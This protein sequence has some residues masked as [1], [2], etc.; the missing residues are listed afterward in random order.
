MGRLESVQQMPAQVVWFD[1]DTIFTTAI[2][3]RDLSGTS[4]RQRSPSRRRR[5]RF[6]H[7]S[8]SLFGLVSTNSRKK[9]ASFSLTR[10][11]IN[12]PF[13]EPDFDGD[14]VH[15]FT[16]I[17]EDTSSAKR[18]HPRYH[19]FNFKVAA[20]PALGLVQSACERCRP[21]PRNAWCMYNARPTRFNH[22]KAY[23][24]RI[25]PRI[26]ARKG[27]ENLIWPRHCVRPR[28]SAPGQCATSTVLCT[29]NLHTLQGRTPL[30][31]RCDCQQR[32]TTPYLLRSLF[33]A[34]ITSEACMHHYQHL[35]TLCH[36][37]SPLPF[38]LASSDQSP[39]AKP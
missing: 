16:V 26:C 13:H 38:I 17:A 18:S 14:Q 30:R 15:S 21:L 4:E 9:T 3:A 28:I 11:T 1:S 37:M 25:V 23:A 32:P 12:S 22:L 33:S 36:G 35:H 7:F 19:D 39:H 34:A 8:A 27:L 31:P 10:S 29:C 6:P 20:L 2:D 24:I 5:H